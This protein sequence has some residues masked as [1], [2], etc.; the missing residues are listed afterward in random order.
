L[1]F[2]LIKGKAYQVQEIEFK[3]YIKDL[4]EN[5]LVSQNSYLAVQNLRKAFPQIAEELKLPTVEK[6]HAGEFL[7]TVNNLI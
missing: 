1:L 2:F 6:L 7:F 3:S 4:K 5:N